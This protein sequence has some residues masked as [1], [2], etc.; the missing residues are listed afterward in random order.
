M[1]PHLLASTL[2]QTS[3]MKGMMTTC[4]SSTRKPFWTPLRH[5]LRARRGS[6]ALWGLHPPPNNQQAPPATLP[7]PLDSKEPQITFQCTAVGVLW[8]LLEHV[9]VGMET[10]EASVEGV[11]GCLSP[12]RENPAAIRGTYSPLL[13]GLQQSLADIA[14]VMRRGMNKCSAKVTTARWPTI[15]GQ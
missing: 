6:T 4:K 10:V 9:Q 1:K 2:L 3:A 14:G 7:R 13:R 15:W 11:D 5:H 12:N 8:E